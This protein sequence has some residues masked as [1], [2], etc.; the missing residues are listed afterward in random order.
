MTSPASDLDATLRDRRFCPSRF[1]KTDH[2]V[3]LVREMTT[4]VEDHE[5]RTGRRQRQRRSQDQ[6]TFEMII[7]AVA[8]DV[9]HRATTEPGGWISISM[10][11][12]IL[13]RPGRYSSPVLGK[14]LPYIVK[15]M[16]Q[17]DVAILELVKGHQ[18]VFGKARLSTMRAG[19]F[20]ADL[21]RSRDIGPEDFGRR[22]GEEVIVLK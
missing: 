7:S 15:V 8:S 22:S 14:T 16:A 1:P 4:R 12:K 5:R 19:S 10:S 3:D 21:V 11:K 6:Q 9:A 20:L 13:G 17:P 18:G 2:A